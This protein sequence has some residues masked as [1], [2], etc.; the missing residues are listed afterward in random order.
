MSNGGY[1]IRN[2]DL[3]PE[4]VKYKENGCASESLGKMLMT[5]A[6]N[7]SSKGSFSG[8]TWREDMVSD[9]VLTCLKYLKNFDEKKSQNAFGYITQI[10]KNAFLTY[11]KDQNKHSVIKDICYKEAVQHIREQADSREVE[12]ELKGINY[13]KFLE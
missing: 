8:Y 6:S 4:I 5:I 1:Y 2:S 9:A 11:I 10:C 7:F 12:K 3:L 13:Q